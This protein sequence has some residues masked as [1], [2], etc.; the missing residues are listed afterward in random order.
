MRHYIITRFNLKNKNWN[1]DKNNQQILT[2][3]WLD[4]R[5]KLFQE[6]CLPSVKKQNNQSFKWFVYFDVG[7]PA[8]YKNIIKDIEKEYSNFTPFF[9]D[10]MN[11]FNQEVVRNVKQDLLV[12]YDESSYILTTRIDND[13]AL[14]QNFINNIQE[15]AKDEHN[16]VIDLRRGLEVVFKDNYFEA[17]SKT[18]YY[19]PFIS[20]V[21]HRDLY[22]SIFSK[23]HVEWQDNTSEV[24]SNKLSWMQIIHTRN[25][26]NK[27][28]YH[29]RLVADVNLE[30]FGII[31]K[32][33]QQ[34]R[35]YIKIY[36]Y[37]IQL[38]EKV[39]QRKPE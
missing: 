39:T 15:L 36:N 31:K 4:D 6:F 10:G 12:D 7:T 32:K 38:Y 13:D 1:L 11:V 9:I 26:H 16:L 34:N 24:V 25:K 23:N 14:H 19:N 20:V 30:D 3:D 2:E 35:V 33:Q 28:N 8:K 17:R 22:Y 21:L 27:T 5:F 29:N 37:L 18:S